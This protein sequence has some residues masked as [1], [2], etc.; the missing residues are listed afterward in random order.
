MELQWENGN[1]TAINRAR[2]SQKM[3]QPTDKSSDSK[4]DLSNTININNQYLLTQ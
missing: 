2:R 3:M 4:E 1:S